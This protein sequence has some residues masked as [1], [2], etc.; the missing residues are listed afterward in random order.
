MM[1]SLLF[2]LATQAQDPTPPQDEAPAMIRKCVDTLVM[3]Q[4]G[5]GA[6][7][8]ESAGHSKGETPIAFRVGGTAVVGIALLSAA[9]EEGPVR[10]AIDRGHTYVLQHLGD[11]LMEPSIDTQVDARIW[12][13]ASALE[14]LCRKRGG[15]PTKGV[16]AWIERLVRTIA[17]EEIPGGGWNYAGHDRPASFVTAPVAQALLWAKSEGFEIPTGLLERSRKSLEDARSAD[18]AFL[19]SGTFKDGRGRKTPDD[20]A[21]SA[22]RAAACE[23]TIR[24]LGGSSDTAIQDALDLFHDHW[25]ELS[26]RSAKPGDHEGPYNIAPYYF[27]FGH[28][29]AGQAIRLLPVPARDR[30]QDRLRVALLKT[31]ENDGTWND[32]NFEGARAYSTAMALLALLGE[33]DLLPY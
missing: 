12:G 8:Y 7:T 16:D 26:Q 20:L 19:Y 5:S 23:S 1:L 4:E 30:E 27:F 28:R 11:P 9:S 15:R 18:G 13:Q 24:L 3:L 29:Y 17:I 22:A 31:R 2:A 14:F 25:W 21:G 32:R 10:Q 33:R 6:W